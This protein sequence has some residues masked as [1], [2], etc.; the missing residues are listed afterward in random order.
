MKKGSLMIDVSY[1]AVVCILIN[2]TKFSAPI[3]TSMASLN[4]LCTL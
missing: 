1:M 3:F 2:E 4:S